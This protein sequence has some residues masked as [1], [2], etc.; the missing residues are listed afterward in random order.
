MSDVL[1]ACGGRSL[2]RE[3]S[4]RSGRRADDALT[5]LGHR[6]TLFDV[7]HTLVDRV[8][9]DRPDFVFIAMH[10][11]GGEDG[12]IQDLLEI[13]KIP[14]TGS[15]ALS[16]GLCLDKH[17]F[18]ARCVDAGVPTPRWHSFTKQAFSDFGA[19]G[20]VDALIEE[21]GLPLVVKPASQGSSLGLRI[22]HERDE[23]GEA[24]LAAM[25]YDERVI[26]EAFVP[27]RELAVTVL[28]P[29]DAPEALP[30]LE[31][32]TD[33][34]FYTFAAHY[35]IGAANITEAGLDPAV[36]DGTSEIARRAYSAAGCRDFARVD[37]RHDGDEPQ[38]LEINT[39]PGLTET[40]P[41]PIAADIAGLSF[42][43]LIA[44]ITQR[45]AG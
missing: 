44:R 14:Y 9:G 7:D 36:L 19:A 17:A 27:G 30:V 31:I 41:T 18:K 34:P 10:G 24:V 2:E 40:G 16:S 35:E 25:S 12:T 20:T 26:V 39:I 5:E 22:V 38:V 11:R 8:T 33:E 4:L 42:P 45:V 28:G 13:L 29:P 37:I 23:F 1:V 21:L 6:V 3:I 32:V 15:D 43:E